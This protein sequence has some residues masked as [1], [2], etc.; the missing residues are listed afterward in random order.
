MTDTLKPVFNTL[1]TIDGAVIGNEKFADLTTLHIG[2]SPLA[3]V[4]CRTTDAV[5]EV[6]RL[7]DSHDIPLLIV[8]GGSNL[9][10]A[11]GEVPVVAVVLE[12]DAIDVDMASGMLR[13]E[14]GAVWDEVVSFSVESGLGGIECLS[15]IPGSA[16]A[17][18]VQNVGAYGVEISDVLTK[19]ELYDRTSGERGWV[20]AD[21]L[22][23]AYRYSN[24]KFTSRAVV[25]AI[26]LQLT[27]DGLSAPL[28]FGE[29]ARTLGLGDS[30]D[31]SSMRMP[32][33]AVRDA[34][35]GLRNGKG[36][37][38]N[39]ADHDTWSAGSFF[40]NPI[41]PIDVAEAVR[42]KAASIRGEEDAVKMPC[43]P[44]GEGLNK[45]SAAWLIDR[46]GFDKGHLATGRDGRAGLS[47]KHTL[48]LT[49]RGNATS[50]DIVA[51]AREVRAGVQD[52]FGVVLEPEP[53]WVGVSID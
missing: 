52:V 34:V 3:T 53:V 6:V 9:V 22:E 17:T 49:N 39:E 28:R 48:A 47:T 13:A 44:A 23:L 19:V 41:V 37:V 27:T 7:L 31:A 21:S 30:A 32:I 5:V 45:L 25:L 40:T 4:H 11:E 8:G 12:C 24:L 1:E 26:E 36:M 46:A 15:G 20:G 35:L 43:F 10:I 51:L 42:L 29:L 16:G 18:P 50:D 2:G 14:A 33:Q 38:Y